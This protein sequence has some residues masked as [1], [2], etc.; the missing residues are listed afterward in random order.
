[1]RITEKIFR[2]DCAA[3]SKKL[4]KMPSKGIAPPAK[5]S[6]PDPFP[7]PSLQFHERLIG[8]DPQPAIDGRDEAEGPVGLGGWA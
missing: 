3:N 2:V 6:C 1:M 5:H 4:G 7:L 8:I